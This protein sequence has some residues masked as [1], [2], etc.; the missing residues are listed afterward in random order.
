MALETMSSAERLDGGQNSL[1]NLLR[2]V[3]PVDRKRDQWD[4]RNSKRVG[5]KGVSLLAVGHIMGSIVE[6]N[7]GND[8]RRLRSDQHEIEMFLGD[9]AAAFA[10]PV[11]DRD[12]IGE[13]HFERDEVTVSNGRPQAFVEEPAFTW[14]QEAPS[15][16]I[17]QPRIKSCQR[18]PINAGSSFTFPIHRRE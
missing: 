4:S 10:F 16:L 9:L 5:H 12:H 11:I 17:W 6:F 1:T 15:P 18:A 3:L 14:A 2:V 8:A 13:L 7:R